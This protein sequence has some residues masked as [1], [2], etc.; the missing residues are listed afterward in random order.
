MARKV[1]FAVFQ[2][3][4]GEHACFTTRRAHNLT[5]GRQEVGLIPGAQFDVLFTYP[6]RMARKVAQ[7]AAQR[8]VDKWVESNMPDIADIR[9]KV[10]EESG[11]QSY[12][13]G[14]EEL[15]KII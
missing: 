4:T 8:A 7:Q 3:A 14:E 12:L 5:A 1:Y 9:R 11:R 10:R 15:G 6:R 13:K 2:T